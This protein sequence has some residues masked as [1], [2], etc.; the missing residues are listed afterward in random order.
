MLLSSQWLYFRGCVALSSLRILFRQGVSYWGRFSERESQGQGVRVSISIHSW[1]SQTTHANMPASPSISLGLHISSLF[2]RKKCQ[3][4]TSLNI[5]P[6]RTNMAFKKCLSLSPL[7]IENFEDCLPVWEGW[8]SISCTAYVFCLY[9]CHAYGKRTLSVDSISP[10]FTKIPS[11]E[12]HKLPSC[13]WR[14]N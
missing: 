2:P 10:K 8:G 6:H 9:L 13:I 7:A 14:V 5:L 4:S 3:I 12:L 11:A 1:G